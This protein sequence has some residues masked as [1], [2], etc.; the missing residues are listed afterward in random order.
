MGQE[1]EQFDSVRGA[2]AERGGVERFDFRT[3]AVERAF[4]RFRMC[5]G[6]EGVA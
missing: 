2:E 4:N 6:P 5:G 1:R 3:G